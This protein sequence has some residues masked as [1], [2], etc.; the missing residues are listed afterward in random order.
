MFEMALSALE[1][2]FDPSRLMF[3]ALGVAIGLA[4]AGTLADVPSSYPFVPYDEALAT[5]IFLGIEL[6]LD[7]SPFN[8]LTA[9]QNRCWKPVVTAVNGMAVGGG[10]HFVADSDLIV[11]AEHAT[12]LDTHVKVGLVAGLEPVGLARRLPLEQVLRMAEEIGCDLIVMA[13][14]NPS[15]AR[16]LLGP[17]A[18]RVVRHANCCVLVVR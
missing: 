12:F 14:G 10:L 13:A 11:C 9:V 1:I 6:E 3:V 18:A 15:L 7:N 2:V 8:Y 5:A 4:T 16:Y 17:N